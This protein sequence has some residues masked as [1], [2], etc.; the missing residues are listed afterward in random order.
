MTLKY[1]TAAGDVVLNEKREVGLKHQMLQWNWNMDWYNKGCY[2][3][4][5][6][7]YKKRVFVESIVINKCPKHNCLI[8]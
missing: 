2:V 4:V 3:L 7:L 8:R 6:L 5:R 1:R